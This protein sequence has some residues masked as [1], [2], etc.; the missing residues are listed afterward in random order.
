MPLALSYLVLAAREIDFQ[1]AKGVRLGWISMTILPLI[2]GAVSSAYR[3]THAPS[4][5]GFSQE[6]C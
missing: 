5:F 4:F 2:Y 3:P 6:L 1:D